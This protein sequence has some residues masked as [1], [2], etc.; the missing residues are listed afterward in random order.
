LLI[1]AYYFYGNAAIAELQEIVEKTGFSSY[2]APWHGVACPHPAFFVFIGAGAQGWGMDN[3]SVLRDK[4]EKLRQ[5][6]RD[7]DDTIRSLQLTGADQMQLARLKKRKLGLKDQMGF[8]ESKLIP[9][10]IA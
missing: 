7:L 9:D 5:E 10:I 4:L 1:T 8:I 6:H 2:N 3:I